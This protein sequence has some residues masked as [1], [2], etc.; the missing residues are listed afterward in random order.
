MRAHPD[1]EAKTLSQPEILVLE[2]GIFLSGKRKDIFLPNS[3]GGRCFLAP[4][5]HF[6]S[7]LQ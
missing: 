2:V 5:G 3:A 4:A 6:K 7:Y 1:L